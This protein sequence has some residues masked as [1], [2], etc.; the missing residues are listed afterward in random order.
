[1]RRVAGLLALGFVCM[2]GTATASS[3]SSGAAASVRAGGRSLTLDVRLLQPALPPPGANSNDFNLYAVGETLGHPA[4]SLVGTMA[5]AL[6]FVPVGGRREIIA[7]TVTTFP[8]G[9]ISAAGS[10]IADGQGFIDVPIQGGTGT[11]KGVSGSIRI[12]LAFNTDVAYHLTIPSAL[13]GARSLTVDVIYA[14]PQVITTHLKLYAIGETLG[15]RA[16]TFLGT[17]SF[18]YHLNP[19][20]CSGSSVGCK[21][22]AD[23][24]TLSTFPNGTIY[25]GGANITLA[26]SGLVVPIQNGTGFFKG[27]SGSILIAPNDEHEAFY[28]LTLPA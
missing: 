19:S 20:L 15:Y 26:T 13:G 1:M 16:G 5:F 12:A 21:G 23:L 25:A 9:E 8:G 14:H 3:A 4:N 7:K 22:S 10:K 2:V 24:H 18:T 11:F 17:M 28:R 27:V 6:Q